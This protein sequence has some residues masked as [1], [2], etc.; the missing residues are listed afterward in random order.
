MDIRARH[1]G[2]G[3]WPVKFGVPP[4]FVMSASWHNFDR[5]PPSWLHMTVSGGTPETTGGTPVPPNPGER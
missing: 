1:G 5:Q 2:T 3:L 4:N